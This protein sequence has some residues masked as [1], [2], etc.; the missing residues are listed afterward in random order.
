MKLQLIEDWGRA[1]RM[2]SIQFSAGFALLFSFGPE[3]IHTWAFMPEDLKNLLP[4]G[5]GRWVA[6]GAFG[7]TLLGRLFKLEKKDETQ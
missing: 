5:T 1:H 2:A 6:V 3:L 4:E 7:L